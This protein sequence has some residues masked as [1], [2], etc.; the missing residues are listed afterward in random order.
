MTGGACFAERE[1]CM[2]KLVAATA[3]AA[4]LSSMVSLPAQ[5]EPGANNGTWSVELVTESGLCSARYSYALAIREGQVQLVS[6]GAGARVSG[7]VGADGSVGLAVTNGTASG[8]GTGRLQAGTGSG[9]WKVASLCSGRWTA[10][11]RDDRTAQAD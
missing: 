5:A 7:H 11:R 4:G 10:R 2:I 1:S 3:L 8:T 6:G 9:T